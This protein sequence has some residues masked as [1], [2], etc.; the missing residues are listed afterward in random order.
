[1]FCRFGSRLDS[2]PVA[3]PTWLNVV[4][5]RPSRGLTSGGSASRYVDFSFD[6]SR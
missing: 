6:S 2:R 4:W 5:M 3:A 1:M